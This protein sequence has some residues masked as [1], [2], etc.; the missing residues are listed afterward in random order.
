MTGTGGPSGPTLGRLPWHWGG[1]YEIGYEQD[2]WLARRRDGHGLLAAST[3]AGLETVIDADY[4]HRPVPRDFD[5]PV[6]EADAGDQDGGSEERPPGQD[7][8]FLLA[9]MQ[10][11]FRTW[12]IT[13]DPG[14]RAWFARTRKTTICENSAV[15][16]CA[17]LL[18]IER[19]YRQQAQPDIS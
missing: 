4:R 3:L 18:L 10:A 19:R 11:A 12:V 14:T 17:A 15:L 9:A 13:Y 2:Q 6:S 16:L 1:A 8:S 7:E 5:P